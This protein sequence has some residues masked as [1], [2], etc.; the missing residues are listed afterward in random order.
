MR[1]L[2]NIEKLMYKIADAGHISI[3]IDGFKWTL[4]QFQ[5]VEENLFDALIGFKVWQKENY[6]EELRKATAQS[7]LGFPE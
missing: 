3:H 7:K 2:S 6:N 1:E 5:S 4:N